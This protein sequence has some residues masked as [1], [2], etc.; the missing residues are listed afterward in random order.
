MSAGTPYRTHRP[1]RE[2]AQRKAGI[3]RRKLADIKSNLKAR[4]A[5]GGGRFKRKVGS[6]LRAIG[7]RLF[8]R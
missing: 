2:F 8:K 5:L 3:A 1:D 6:R 4:S 7:K